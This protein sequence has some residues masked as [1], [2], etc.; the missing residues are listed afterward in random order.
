MPHMKNEKD[1]RTFWN[2]YARL[3][4]VEINRFNR[5]AYAEMCRLM[6]GALEQEMRVLGYKMVM[7][8]TQV[9]EEA[10]HFYRK[11]G[12]VEKGSLSF[13]NTPLTQP[14]EMFMMKSL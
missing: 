2:R 5:P 8:S 10:Q 11:L 12:Y 3:Y 6:R 9:N 7:T 4:D 13:D 1:N 14:L